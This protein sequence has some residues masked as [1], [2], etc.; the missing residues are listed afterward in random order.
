MISI[1]HADATGM[2][3]CLVSG[4]CDPQGRVPVTKHLSRV[5]ALR[6]G[7]VLNWHVGMVDEEEIRA[8]APYVDVIS[9]DFVGDNETIWDV[10]GLNH[11]V[12]DCART[13]VMLQQYATVIPHLT[14][15]LHGGQF[16][17]EYRALLILE[18]LG[19][20]ALVV[21]VLIPTP[22]TRYAGC[23]PP[24]IEEVVDFFSAARCTLPD[25]PIYL[26]CMRPGGHYR[27]EL[28]PLAVRAGVNKIVNPAPSAIRAADDLGLDIQWEDEC[29]VIRRR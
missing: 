11:T 20:H 1:E 8:I 9:F 25:T 6:P 18:A 22:G 24:S 17:G 14:L 3:S 28:D 2:T 19:L 23:Q 7:R 10:Y 5:A 26:G 4:G 29:C 27:H 16:G 15:G 12:D 13:Y 21:L